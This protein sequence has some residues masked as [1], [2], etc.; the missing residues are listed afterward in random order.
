MGREYLLNLC[1]RTVNLRRPERARNEESPLGVLHLAGLRIRATPECRKGSSGC[2]RCGAGAGC[3]AIKYKSL[4][5]R[6]CTAQVRSYEL[7]GCFPYIL[8]RGYVYQ[9]PLERLT[10]SSTQA[11]KKSARL[12]RTPKTVP[13][14]GGRL[15]A[16][17][18]SG[19][20]TFLKLK[21]CACGT[22]PST[23][24]R[25]RARCHQVGESK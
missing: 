12:K 17:H 14:G 1:R 23:L 4:S 8:K 3:S 2:A 5:G 10:P 25:E 15:L 7:S 18:Q 6:G 19:W 22:N 11:W 16:L 20:L 13:S 24:E 21:S 9:V